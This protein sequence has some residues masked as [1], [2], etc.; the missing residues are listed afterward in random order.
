LLKALPIIA[1]VLFV[2]CLPALLFT[3][4]IRYAVN[5]PR[6]YEYSFNKYDAVDVTGI[7]RPELN[8]AAREMIH[9]FNSGD[10]LIDIKVTVDDEQ[11]DL[12]TSKEVAHLKD[13]KHLIQT[14]Y[15]VQIGT[16]AYV[17][18]FVIGTL[19]LSKGRRWRWLFG[20]FMAGSVFTLFLMFILG[21][22]ALFGF[23]QF[24]LD[25]HNMSFSNQLWQLEEWDVLPQMFPEGFFYDA[26]KFITLAIVSE[27]VLLGC[28]S[29]GLLFKTR[30]NKTQATSG[31]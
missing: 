2:L 20:W 9:Y 25:F 4:N 6:L 22:M 29:G 15:W 28:I 27:V 10:K 17:L 18:A 3:S 26:T 12:F 23:D 16:L 8:R 7:D 5:S 24:F 19:A 14:D 31:K 11:Y 21:L 30:K 13:I 1:G